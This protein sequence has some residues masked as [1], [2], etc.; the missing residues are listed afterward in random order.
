[1]RVE[2]LTESVRAALDQFGPVQA[3]GTTATVELRGEGRVP[4][5]A[6]AVVASG[7]R[8]EALIPQR[9]TLEDMFVRVVEGSGVE[10]KT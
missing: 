9:E 5:L 2:A 4:D 1:V 3:N 8:L 7:G 10:E 6:E